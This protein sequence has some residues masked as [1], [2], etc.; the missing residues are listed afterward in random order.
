MF[1]APVSIPSRE[2]VK[3]MDSSQNNLLVQEISNKLNIYGSSRSALPFILPILQ[4]AESQDLKTGILFIAEKLDIPPVEVFSLLSFYQNSNKHRGKQVDIRLCKSVLFGKEKVKELAQALQSKFQIDFGQTSEDGSTSLNWSACAG[5]PN[6]A[7][8]LLVNDEIYTRVKPEDLDEIVASFGNQIY[9]ANYALPYTWIEPL[10]FSGIKQGKA[11]NALSKNNPHPNQPGAYQT[12][13]CNVDEGEPLTFKSRALLTEYFE[14][15][16]EGML[17]VAYTNGINHGL[18][19]LPKRYSY[20]KSLLEQR[21]SQFRSRKALG[22]NIPGLNGFNFDVELLVGLG[23]Y[24]GHEESA[25]AAMLNGFRP[26]FNP[27]DERGT[28]PFL[29][30]PVD[31]FLK[32]AYV[33]S[34]SSEPMDDLEDQITQMPLIASVSGDCT[35][36]GVYEIQPGTSIK[37]FLKR[38]G[39]SDAY[40]V[41]IGGL[42]SEWILAE[43]FEHPLDKEMLNKTAS[44]I[45]YGPQINLLEAAKDILAYFHDASCGQ[46]TPCRNG[47]PV[48][49][50]SLQPAVKNSKKKKSISE[51]RSLAETI[52]LTSKCSLGQCAP[53]AYL[54]ILNIVEQNQRINRA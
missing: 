29:I 2:E 40:A 22:E 45:V 44:I 46:C 31:F 52:Q 36:S 38:V 24:V 3:P 4:N 47:I 23:D 27:S 14:L 19:Y 50:K 28:A 21:L 5:Y 12:L 32:A 43:D 33:A 1:F 41:Q 39:G 48:L 16:L 8:V 15:T 49:I 51:M 34:K 53:N 11:I 42:S 18:I 10:I 20:M 54:S 37:N 9:S 30:R 17:I 7:P 26:E 6:Q 13:V 35:Q 25:L